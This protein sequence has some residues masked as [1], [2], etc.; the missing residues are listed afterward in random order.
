VRLVFEISVFI[1][2]E[3]LNSAAF[4]AGAVAI[5]LCALVLENSCAAANVSLESV[6]VKLHVRLN[7]T[8]RRKSL[9]DLCFALVISHYKHCSQKVDYLN[10]QYN[11][12]TDCRIIQTFL[13]K[14]LN[15]LST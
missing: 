9:I 10:L 15:F 12:I 2:S 11:N 3:I 14:T 8:C 1:K 13:I 4:L 5:T 6:G 7:N